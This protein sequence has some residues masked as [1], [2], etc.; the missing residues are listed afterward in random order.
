MLNSTNQQCDN[1]QNQNN[2]CLLSII[3]MYLTFVLALQFAQ[4]ATERLKG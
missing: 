1:Y 4:K 3:I 2:Y